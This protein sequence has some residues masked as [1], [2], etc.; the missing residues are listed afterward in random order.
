VAPRGNRNFDNNTI[1]VVYLVDEGARVFIEDI[2]VLGNDRTRD[3]VIRREFDISEGD[4]YNRVLVQKTRRRIEALGFFESVRVTTQPGSAPDR[5]RV[6]VNVIEKSTGDISLSGGY[7]NNGGPS[8]QISLT[9]RN[10]LGR[11]QF[12]NVAYQT[13]DDE[14][15][16]SFQFREPFFLGYRVSAGFGIQATESEA[17]AERAYANDTI[18]GNVSFGIPIT[19]NLGTSVFYTF[20]N[21]D[22]TVG[23]A[24]LDDGVAPP[25]TDDG[26]QG[27]IA[28]ELSA[29]LA[30]DVGDFTASGLGF[31]VTYNTLDN[32]RKPREGMRLHWT[33]TFYGA[34]GDAQYMASEVNL[35]NYNLLSEEEDIVLFGR[36][37]AGHLEQFGGDGTNSITDTLRT[38]DNFQARSKTIRG[39]DS[40]GYGPRDPFTGDP[41]G[42]Q[43]YWNATAEVQFPLPFISRSVGLR[44]AF[45]ADAGQLYDP[46]AGTIAAIQA[47]PGFGAL[48]NQNELTSDSIRASVGGS[49][50][51]DSPFGPL[52]V[53][54][55]FP[56]AEESFDDIEELNFGVSSAF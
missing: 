20:R 23:T 51:W 17:T 36:V 40:F 42:G 35:V 38:A 5:I 29:A 47:I 18:A 28:G 24:L 55:A 27:N 54:Y 2:V 12:L 22:I 14:D 53:D 37:R 1:D 41:L 32:N 11:G 46:G 15:S 10:F 9:E 19:E 33:Q 49:V 43:T 50:I 7:S 44:G 30:D 8:A 39:F 26:I 6:I 13:G 52:R 16:Y 4:A 21:S 31:S 3:Y 45:F 25:A 48:T 34:G 56:I